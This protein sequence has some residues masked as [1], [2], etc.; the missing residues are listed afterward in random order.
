MGILKQHFVVF[1]HKMIVVM[2]QWPDTTSDCLDSI[3]VFSKEGIRQTI[4]M[5]SL[6]PVRSS[7]A[8]NK[9]YVVVY[10]AVVLSVAGVRLF[11]L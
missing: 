3:G 7:Q 11:S 4:K 8:G 5:F 9:S 10:H 2:T 1:H 6:V